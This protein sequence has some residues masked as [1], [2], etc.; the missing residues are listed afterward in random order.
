M[1]SLKHT[2]AGVELG[3][4][5]I[6]SSAELQRIQDSLA[7]AMG[8]A[9]RITALDGQNLT[10]PSNVSRFCREFCRFRMVMDATCLRA[11]NRSDD[12]TTLSVWTCQGAGLWEACVGIY[13]S[14]V[15][16]ANWLIGQARV[17]STEPEAGTAIVQ[18]SDAE[19]RKALLELPEL[20]RER[21]E[22]IVQAHVVAIEVLAEKGYQAAM[23]RLETRER[24]IRDEIRQTLMNKSRDGIVIVDG[25]H[26][27]IEANDCFAAML[28]Y[29]P[30]EVLTLKTWDYEARMSEGDIKRNF[31]ALGSVNMLFETQH[32]RKDGA[33]VDVE[34]SVSGEMIGERHCVIGICRDITEKKRI[35]QWQRILL[36][37][38]EQ[39][40]VSIVMTDTDGRIEYVNPKLS[41]VSGYTFEEVRGK[42]PEMFASGLDESR[43]SQEMWRIV[44]GGGLWSGEFRNRHKNGSIYIEKALIAPIRDSTGVITHF[45]AIK[46]DVTQSRRAEEELLKKDIDFRKFLDL[47]PQRV[48]FIDRDLNYQFVNKAYAA[49]LP[50]MAGAR[51]VRDLLT[52][53]DFLQMQPVIADVLEG[54]AIHF[55]RYLEYWNGTVRY[56]DGN[57]IPE[58][59]LDGEVLGFYAVLND[60][61]ELKQIEERLRLA[62]DA[63]EAANRLKS[64]FLANMSHEVRT[65]LNGILGVLQIL[66]TTPLDEEQQ[67]YV[68]LAV[69]SSQR[70]TRLLSDILDISKIEADKLLIQAQ[71]FDPRNFG[72]S[73]GDLFR[74]GLI[75]KKLDF[76]FLCG[77]DIPCSVV[78]DEARTLQILFNLVGNA[79]KFT[80]SGY[81]R[82][83][84]T[85]LPFAAPGQMRLLACVEDSG[86]GISE[87]AQDSI[88]EP[89][90]QL[91]S[92]Y[93]KR[94]QGVGLGLTI[95]SKLVM[96][97]GGSVCLES[98]L[99]QGTAFYVSLPF[100]CP[101][102]ES[103]NSSAGP[104]P[105]ASSTDLSVLLVED[106]DINL[107]CA[108]TILEKLGHQVTT[109][110]NGQEAFELFAK[111][112]FDLILVDIQMPIMD[113]LALTKAIRKLEAGKAHIPIIALTAHVMSGDRE[114]F[115]SADMDGYVSKPFEIDVMEREIR[116]VLGA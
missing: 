17:P 108:R 83:A 26:T 46:E 94:H 28:G 53:T 3:F 22:A 13:V 63:A 79:L 111:Q 92:S 20:T 44:S 37:M 95:V 35:E 40:P 14:G 31:P 61:T 33:M 110:V 4:D 12:A 16:V 74:S 34:V 19:V 72:R 54:K 1:L 112:Q 115:L 42:N 45:V 102:D 64:E 7:L 38:V 114:R 106:D 29:T 93:T 39:S 89:F 62:K 78:G 116:L 11:R 21:F 6:F 84:I 90:M 96:R 86:P 98:A 5:D 66:Q 2:E 71:P 107:R 36:Q 104:L 43:E 60:L 49:I 59:S 75:D 105:K 109:A 55:V 51:S 69:T 47:L 25:D 85:R 77:N 57:L 101:Q 24:R 58:I 81:V 23:L 27:I 82:V 76:Q 68:Q 113:G 99:G 91:D 32:R 48:A 100:A 65:P 30:E 87:E 9:S 67:E 10:S 97:M 15:R 103:D 80:D 73:L 8:V 56:V 52:A 70:L 88:F 50:D 41:E 18:E